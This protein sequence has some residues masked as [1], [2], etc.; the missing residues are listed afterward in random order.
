MNNGPKLW[1]DLIKQAPKGSVLMGG[2]VVDYLMGVIPKDYD[3]FHTYKEGMPKNLPPWWKYLEVV[4]EE[5]HGEEY[6]EGQN[7]DGNHSIGSIYNYL[8]SHKYRVQLIGVFY[9]DPKEHFKN[10]DHSLTLGRYTQN[11]LFIHD[12]VFRSIEGEYIEY[13]SKNKSAKAIARSMDRAKA[14]AQKY[15]FVDPSYKN[16]GG[17]GIQVVEGFDL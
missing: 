2:A 9:D 15:G 12:K 1:A 10:F 16:F 14:K 13:V 6:F 5:A 3:I 11:G 4:D 17:N 8:V 7:P